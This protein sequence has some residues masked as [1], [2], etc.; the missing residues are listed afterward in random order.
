MAAPWDG[1]ALRGFVRHHATLL[2]PP[3]RARR[4]S[5]LLRSRSRSPISVGESA[6]LRSGRLNRFRWIARR[7]RRFDP[8]AAAG[9]VSI[10]S[11]TRTYQ[12]N[13]R[14]PDQPTDIEDEKQ[15]LDGM[16]DSADG[17]TR[18]LIRKDSWQLVLAT[19]AHRGRTYWSF[20][21]GSS[22]FIPDTQKFALRY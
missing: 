17:P 18:V 9:G 10:E 2:I 1:T 8:F 5:T 6:S 16:V 12:A 19:R 4:R 15:R 20:E 11:P 13:G 14:K 7:P 3:E 21:R 22:I